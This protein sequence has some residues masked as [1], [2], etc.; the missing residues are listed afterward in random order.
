M[1]EALIF[2]FFYLLISIMV[3]YLLKVFILNNASWEDA[4]ERKILEDEKSLS[5]CVSLMSILWIIYIPYLVIST[6]IKYRKDTN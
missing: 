2:T 3:Y 6:Y 1:R 4:E 5:I